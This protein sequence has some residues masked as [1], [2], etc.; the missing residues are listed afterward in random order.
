[1][2]SLIFKR[3]ESPKKMEKV[4]EFDKLDS[5]E[6]EV[7][8]NNLFNTSTDENYCQP[9]NLPS[10]NNLPHSSTCSYG[11]QALLNNVHRGYVTDGE[12]TPDQIGSNTDDQDTSQQHESEILR[13]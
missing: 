1:M 13:S 11:I 3:S 10:L 9:C 4:K 2:H 8:S 5:S 6:D 12:R 7:D